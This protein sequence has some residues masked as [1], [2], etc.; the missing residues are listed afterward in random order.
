MDD[1]E[2]RAVDSAVAVGAATVIDGVAVATAVATAVPLAA[3]G[4][5]DG[6]ITGVDA[7]EAAVGEATARGVVAGIGVMDW[8]E[9]APNE[10][11]GGTGSTL[12][13]DAPVAIQETCTA[14]GVVESGSRRQT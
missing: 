13:A 3:A 7:A 11:R 12:S 2:G 4:A 8:A 9:E 1:G 5:V 14:R 10:G 6:V